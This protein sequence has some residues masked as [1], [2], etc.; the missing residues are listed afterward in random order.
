VLE[1]RT[2]HVESRLVGK[3]HITGMALGDMGLLQ[4]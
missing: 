2:D 3:P 4:V 1:E